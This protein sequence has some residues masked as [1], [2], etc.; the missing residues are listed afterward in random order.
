MDNTSRRP[1][2][3][4]VKYATAFPV[5]YLSAAQRLVVSDLINEKGKQAAEEAWHGEHPLFRLWWAP[6]IVYILD[7]LFNFTPGFF[8]QRLTLCTHSGGM[9]QMIGDWNYSN[10][11]PKHPADL[12]LLDVSFSLTSIPGLRFLDHT[13]PP[14]K[15][16]IILHIHLDYDLR[17]CILYLSI[18]Y[19]Y[20]STSSSG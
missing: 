17:Y 6:T 16:K 12:S 9:L 18:R 14:R 8:S 5:M 1:L 11:V 19:W 20:F 10:P 15:V 2:A 4:A 7:L 3:N 13:V